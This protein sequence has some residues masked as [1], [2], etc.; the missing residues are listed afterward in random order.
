MNERPY[1]V[2]LDRRRAIALALDAATEADVVVIA[3]KGH[4]TTQQIGDTY[5]PFDD[6]DVTREIL[7]EL[8]HA[9]R[10]GGRLR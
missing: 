7:R 2:E 9:H 6:R 4:E 5:I 8:G 1:A 3:G 10:N